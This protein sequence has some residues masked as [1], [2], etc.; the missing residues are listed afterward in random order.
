MLLEAEDSG[1]THES[2]WG[3]ESQL[4]ATSPSMNMASQFIND[5]REREREDHEN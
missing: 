3:L 4:L 2:R 1:P 5:H